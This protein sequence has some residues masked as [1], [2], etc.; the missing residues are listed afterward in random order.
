[1]KNKEPRSTDYETPK[2]Y[3]MPVN[4]REARR[5]AEVISKE[6]VVE[7]LDLEDA[8]NANAAKAY[9]E[10]LVEGVRHNGKEVLYYLY[11]DTGIPVDEIVVGEIGGIPAE[12]S[13]ALLNKAK[14]R[15]VISVHNHPSNE[16]FSARD[17]F[18]TGKHANIV[19]STVVGHDGSIY[20]V[21]VD[22][23]ADY[24]ILKN[25]YNDL[26]SK[27]SLDLDYSILGEQILRNDVI[28]EICYRRGWQY[29]RR[30][31]YE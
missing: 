8:A 13:Q 31:Y 15:D 2:G 5:L 11:A 9:A 6:H 3:E 20:E 18:T 27:L 7:L 1:M 30:Y 12:K 21:V 24:L 10:I 28:E 17:L 25:E 26:L 22:H 23:A 19:M 29:I 14:E 16:S 4:L